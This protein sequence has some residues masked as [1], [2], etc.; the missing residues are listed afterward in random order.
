[1]MVDL[2]E[3]LV[4]IHQ[5]TVSCPHHYEIRNHRGVGQWYLF[6]Q[7]ESGEVDYITLP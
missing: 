7:F 2:I 3:F 4:L 1:M 6:W 5:S